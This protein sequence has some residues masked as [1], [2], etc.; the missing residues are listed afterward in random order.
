MLKIV[1]YDIW[2]EKC[3]HK[4]LKE[5]EDPCDR[6]LQEPVN[7]DSRKPTEWEEANSSGT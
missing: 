1:D 2:C 7:D 5:T 4:D 3:K 6:C